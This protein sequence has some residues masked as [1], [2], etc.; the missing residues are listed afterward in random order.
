MRAINLPAIVPDYPAVE[1]A[2]AGTGGNVLIAKA[3]PARWSI[4]FCATN[5]QTFQ[6]S[7][8]PKAQAG[9][10]LNVPN[11]AAM[12]TIDFARFPGLVGLEWYW[13]ASMNLS[14]ITIF[15]CFMRPRNTPWT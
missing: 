1:T 5:S 4:S 13:I 3:D 15:E 6:V 9:D 2:I 8:N 7:T 11:T 12:V 14:R 10:G